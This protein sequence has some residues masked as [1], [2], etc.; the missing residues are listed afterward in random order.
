MD[1]KVRASSQ[2]NE[3]ISESN[4]CESDEHIRLLLVTFT[5]V[6]TQGVIDGSSLPRS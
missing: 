3:S 5:L 6:S 4:E 1:R 2:K